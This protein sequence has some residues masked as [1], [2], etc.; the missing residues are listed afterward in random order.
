MKPFKTAL[1]TM[2]I[3]EE[4][5]EI[6]V[7]EAMRKVSEIGYNC[8]EISGH[9]ECNESFV[10]ELCRARDD[11][12]METCALSVVYNADAPAFSPFKGFVPNRLVEDFDRVVA[13]CE[14]LNCR[15]VRYA[16]INA[17][18]LDTMDKV[19]HYFEYTE[20]ICLRLAEKGIKLCMHNHE[21]EF[22]KIGGKTYFDWAIEL[23]PHLCFEFDVLGT[24]HAAVNLEDA[25]EKIKGRVPLIHFED[26]KVTPKKMAFPKRPHLE[27]VITGC[28]LGEGNIDF[29]KFCNKAIECGNE[30]FIIEVSD[31]HGVDT[32]AGMKQAVDNLKN[33][34]FAHTF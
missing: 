6:G 27:E 26:I 1:Q 5:D 13:F 24:A 2:V 30:Y 28:P 16:G 15:Y 9:F 18:E 12:G 20:Q 34:G 19:R 4:L 17:T 21:A 10:D 22:A 7:Y 32:Y 29:K 8:V 11:F 31:F 3:A 25:L 33:G 23:A 14:K